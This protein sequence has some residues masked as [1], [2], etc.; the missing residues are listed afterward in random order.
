MA[1]DPSVGKDELGRGPDGVHIPTPRRR[2]TDQPGWGRGATI[3]DLVIMG[4]TIL[5]VVGT[6]AGVGI[7][8]FQ[9]D[10]KSEVAALK[11]EE[12]NRNIAIE[13]ARKERVLQICREIVRNRS[14][15]V[16]LINAAFPPDQPQNTAIYRRFE[17]L[18]QSL[19]APVKCPGINRRLKIPEITFPD[20]A[21]LASLP[22]SGP[23]EFVDEEDPDV[24]T[25]PAPRPPRPSPNPPE[26]V[27]PPT[28]TT[29]VITTVPV[30]TPPPPP[31]TVQVP[32]NPP[33]GP[34]ERVCRLLDVKLLSLRV[35]L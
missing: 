17:Q 18:R 25:P 20:I 31:V 15:S 2:M 26:P 3:R 9:E 22:A 29:T 32:V 10:N 14:I 30:P 33:P 16:A 12:R 11:M 28:R 5:F 19:S 34:P 1:S 24:V 21:E 27:K 23:L 6:I 35:C 8:L 4:M 7:Y 13:A